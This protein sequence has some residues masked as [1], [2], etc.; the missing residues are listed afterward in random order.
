[1]TVHEHDIER[2][3]A[4]M[5][6]DVPV[7]QGD[8]DRAFAA[9][10]RK[11]VRAARRRRGERLVAACAAA[12]LLIV[13]GAAGFRALGDRDR[14]RPEPAGP[15]TTSRTSVISAG[16]MVGAWLMHADWL[17]PEPVKWTFNADGSGGYTDSANTP[18]VPF[19]YSLSARSLGARDATGCNFS[20]HLT[21]YTQGTLTASVNDHCRNTGPGISLVRL[22]PASPAGMAI[23]MPSMA[24]AGPARRIGQVAGVWLM[25]GTGM[26]L[27]IEARDAA[28][29]TYRLDDQGR[30]DRGPR[31]SGVATMAPDGTLTLDSSGAPPSGCTAAQGTRI[32]LRGISVKAGKGLVAGGGLTSTCP[33]VALQPRWIMV[34]RH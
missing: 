1:M 28:H 22:S 3:L 12:V 2:A 14:G 34:S 26:M 21:G 8:V 4:L 19:Q 29:A 10:E 20:Y 5:A 15:P 23:A 30:L 31:D 9:L 17:S 6:D 25:P 18:D 32:V 24:G 11:Y 33:R 16:E 13:G 7:T 27:A